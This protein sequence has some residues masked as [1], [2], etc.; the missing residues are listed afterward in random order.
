LLEPGV[1]VEALRTTDGLLFAAYA[2][3]MFTA[4][5]LGLSNDTLLARGLRKLLKKYEGINNEETHIVH[6]ISPMV[7]TVQLG[8]TLGV[9]DTFCGA[10][11]T[12]EEGGTA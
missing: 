7:K 5:T 4:D 9:L 6:S 1:I 12:V 2:S 11:I 3:R 10:G 8:T